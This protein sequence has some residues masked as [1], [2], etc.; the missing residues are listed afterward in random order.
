MLP[1]EKGRQETYGH[2]DL[3]YVKSIHTR[4]EKKRTC[5]EVTKMYKEVAFR[6]WN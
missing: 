4:A 5:K 3:S 2:H 6:W 1:S